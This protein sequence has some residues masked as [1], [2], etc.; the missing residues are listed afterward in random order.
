MKHL[1]PYILLLVLLCAV[2]LFAA[3]GV[4]ESFAIFI[5]SP[6]ERTD[7][8]FGTGE[9]EIT[10]QLTD[11]N[12]CTTNLRILMDAVRKGNRDWTAILASTNAS[13]LSQYP[14][15]SRE[16]MTRTAFQEGQR[17]ML[18]MQETVKKYPV[19]DECFQ[20]HPQ[21]ITEFSATLRSMAESMKLFRGVLGS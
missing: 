2:S 5:P 17:I 18:G 21:E 1:I 3:Q 6:R 12:P 13:S 7:P 15:E 9:V 10:T 14:A 4:K 8:G 16:V 11:G 19:A 20:Q